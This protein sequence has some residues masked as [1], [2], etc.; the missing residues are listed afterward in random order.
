MGKVA[1]TV[2]MVEMEEHIQ[3]ARRNLAVA[4][5]FGDDAAKAVAPVAMAHALVVIAECVYRRE[6]REGL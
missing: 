5:E 4:S 6:M 2:N 1:P 3:E